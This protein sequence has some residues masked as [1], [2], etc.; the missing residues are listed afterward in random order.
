M[1]NANDLLWW[2][3]VDDRCRLN[4]GPFCA[5]VTAE[6]DRWR[7][8]YNVARIGSSAYGF[9]DTR[10]AAMQAAVD[11][12]EA[13]GVDFSEAPR[14]KTGR[15]LFSFLAWGL[16]L[17]AWVCR[18]LRWVV[19]DDADGTLADGTAPTESLARTAAIAAMRRE[20]QKL[21]EK[22]KGELGV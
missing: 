19:A 21:I 17:G 7:W 15:E 1:T 20:V 11:A 18:D 6:Y 3:D 5:G 2:D 22:A 16:G 14:W 8:R 9:A 10:E 13:A 4:H 12:A